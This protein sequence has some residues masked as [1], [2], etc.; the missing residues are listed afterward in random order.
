MNISDFLFVRKNFGGKGFQINYAFD[1][2]GQ[3]EYTG[4]ARAGIADSDRGWQIVKKTWSSNFPS[5]DRVSHDN[6]IW[7]ERT[8]LF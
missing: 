2:N 7:D 5:K 8:T 1:G 4:Y 6:E 3:L